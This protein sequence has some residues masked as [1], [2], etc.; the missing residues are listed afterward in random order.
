MKM[1]ECRAAHSNL[2]FVLGFQGVEAGTAH[3]PPEKFSFAVKKE[4][5]VLTMYF[6]DAFVRLRS[7]FS[8]LDIVL[9]TGHIAAYETCLLSP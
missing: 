9:Y 8:W 3:K 1:M 6:N 5:C 4:E 2:L 7:P